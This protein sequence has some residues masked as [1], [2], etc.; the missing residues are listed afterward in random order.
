LYVIVA[1]GKVKPEHL[2]RYLEEILLDA[3]GSVNNEPGCLR[4]DVIQDRDEPARVCLYEIYRDA[5]AFQAHLVAPHF[6]RY[7]EASRDVWDEPLNVVHGTSFTLTE[8]NRTG[9]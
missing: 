8:E 4:F 5:D 9:G 2:G 6:K 1:V 3:I 7:A